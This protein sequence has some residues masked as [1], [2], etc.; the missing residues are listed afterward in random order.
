[1]TL[2]KSYRL[3]SRDRTFFHL[4]KKTSADVT[5]NNYLSTYSTT[6]YMPG[7]VLLGLAIKY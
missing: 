3:V 6:R 1:M 7:H 5:I 2:V 4:S